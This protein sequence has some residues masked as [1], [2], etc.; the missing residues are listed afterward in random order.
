[1][2]F[3][4]KMIGAIIGKPP[5]FFKESLANFTVQNLKILAA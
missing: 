4:L 3:D 5:D 2:V 1:M